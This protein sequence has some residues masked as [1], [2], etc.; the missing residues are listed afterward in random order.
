LQLRK[1]EETVFEI[2]K[3]SETEQIK[4]LIS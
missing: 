2:L 4:N 3:S 1:K